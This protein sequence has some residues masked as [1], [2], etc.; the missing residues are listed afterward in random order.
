MLYS[1]VAVIGV[2]PA[3]FIK[4]IPNGVAIIPME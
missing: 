4:N 2:P 3:I 1:N